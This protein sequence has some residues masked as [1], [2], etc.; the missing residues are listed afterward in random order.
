MLG[1]SFL[2][3]Y[4]FKRVVE[5]EERFGFMGID[6]G[7]DFWIGIDFGCD[8]CMGDRFWGVIFGWVLIWFDGYRFWVRFSYGYQFRG[9][10][11][12]FNG[13]RVFDFILFFFNF[14]S[15]LNQT[16]NKETPKKLV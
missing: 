11:F 5:A 10:I 4:L 15:T 12:G 8:F 6:F 13:R 9:V 2:Y 7:Y 14:I 3:K 16:N 1:S